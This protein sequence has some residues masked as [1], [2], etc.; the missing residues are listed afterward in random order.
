MENG[1]AAAMRDGIEDRLAAVRKPN[2]ARRPR[3]R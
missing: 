1:L 2:C 3:Q